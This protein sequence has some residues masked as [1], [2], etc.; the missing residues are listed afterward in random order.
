MIKRSLRRRSATLRHRVLNHATNGSMRGSHITAP[1]DR[2]TR[3][4]VELFRAHVGDLFLNR[5]VFDGG[6]Y[7]TSI[8]VARNVRIAGSTFRSRASIG[9][10]VAGPDF[11]GAL[12]L[13]NSDIRGSLR[14]SP[15]STGSPIHFVG[16][17]T[18]SGASCKQL[19]VSKE[20]LESCES[21]DLEGLDYQRLSHISAVELL[22]F[23]ETCPDIY[24]QAYA[25]L[26]AY[27]QSA[28][29]VAT[30]RR[31]LIALERRRTR[32][33]P[34]LSLRWAGGMLHNVLVG[35]CYR[36]GRA[37]PWLLAVLIGA[38]LL[39]HDHGEFLIRKS[40]S[41]PPESALTSWSEAVQYVLDSLLPFANLGTK[42]LWLI[43]ADSA[44]ELGW[45]IGFMMLK[46][47]AWGLAALSLLSFTAVVRKAH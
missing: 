33:A 2:P 16:P 37:L 6:V 46:F 14:M 42:D 28:G 32:S 26:A 12:T 3:M 43:Q 18:L 4:A 31:A 19:V 20:T 27:C 8:T 5:A 7:A 41:P 17:V 39:V 29:D 13:A 40:M 34:R 11:K 24:P 10:E 22:D 21:V 25:G 23:L 47:L 30:R 15:V 38:V 1:V 44:G 45:L 9:W 35:Y 36:P